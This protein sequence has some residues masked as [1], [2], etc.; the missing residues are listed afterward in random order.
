MN[1]IKNNLFILFLFLTLGIL[2]PLRILGI[3]MVTQS[4]IFENVLRGSEVVE[5]LI[6]LNSQDKDITYELVAEGEIASWASFYNVEDRKLENPIKEITLSPKSQERI[7]VKF[8]IPEDVPNGT[9]KGEVAIM[10][11]PP[12]NT[13]GVIS[14]S[15][16]QRVGRPVS[17]TISDKEILDFQ[18]TIFPL[19]YAIGKNQPLKIKIIYTNN[20]NV[21]IQPSVHLKII[22]VSTGK[23]VHNAIYPYPEDEPPVKPF[24]RRVLPELIEWQTAGQKNGLYEAQIKVL[25]DGET[26]FE[27]SFRFRV[28]ID[29]M[30]LLLASIGKLGGG[31]ILLGWFVLGAIFLSLAAILTIF[32]QNKKIGG[33]IKIL[34]KNFKINRYL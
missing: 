29:I 6:L 25:L 34:F 12:E 18:P 16:I 19:K 3:G 21:F 4:I 22:Q 26:Y 13:E 7:I 15:V 20:G 24:E 27:K 31:N 32:T 1:F 28:G 2:V 23:V 17:I 33:K 9:Y 11:K 30:E 5:T 14:V 10:T 8:T